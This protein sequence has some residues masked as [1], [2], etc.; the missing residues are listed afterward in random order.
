MGG[1]RV[2]DSIPSSAENDSNA[3]PP[4][5]GSYMAAQANGLGFG[6]RTFYEAPKG[7]PFSFCFIFAFVHFRI[8]TSMGSWNC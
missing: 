3:I 7:R 6:S 2:T 4:Q 1:K 5:R 8:P